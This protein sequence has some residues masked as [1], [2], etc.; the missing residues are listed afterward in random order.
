MRALIRVLAIGMAWATALAAQSGANASMENLYLTHRWFELR[1]AIAGKPV[2]P[3]YSGAVATAF[4]RDAD[5]ER[6]LRLA[7]REAPT[8]NRANDVRELLLSIY[9]R[10]GRSADAVRLLDEAV[11]AAPSQ[12][13]IKNLRSAFMP[14]ANS[15]DQSATVGRGQPFQCTVR[16]DGVFLPITV[17][18]KPVE[19]LFDS[20]ASNAA[21]TETEA[22]TLGIAVSSVSAKVGDFAGG[23]ASMRTGIADRITIGDAEL[24]H[25]PV[26]IFPDTQ[27]PWNDQPPGKRGAIGL[28]PI[29]ALQG[30]RWTKSGTCSVG[31]DSGSR[32]VSSAAGSAPQN[33]AFDGSTPVIRVQMD[34][35]PLD[36]VLDTGNQ[37]GFQLWERFG[38]DFPALTRS[39]RRTTTSV[40]Q[41]GGSTNR[42]VVEIP[43]L[44]LT[45]G[46]FDTLIRPARLFS[47]PIGTEFQHGNIGMSVLSQAAEVRID[48]RAMTVSLR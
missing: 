39:G 25:V 43:E 23:T 21:L 34:S 1:D 20:G 16:D 42:D 29:L 27:P 38:F 36:F 32:A 26:L 28:P 7:I 48:F 33:L 45:V 47:K 41:I 44:H 17:N 40:E 10:T 30:I 18:R 9:M 12:D 11:A 5:A 31:P 35:K 3:L 22:R 15:P 8:K 13:D 14:L 4:N 6:D 2:P 46:G 19:W 37:G 24:R